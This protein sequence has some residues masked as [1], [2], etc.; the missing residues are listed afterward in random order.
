MSAF[1]KKYSEAGGRPEEFRRN[2]I[3]S[4]KETTTPRAK[5]LADK[6]RRDPYSQHYQ[7]QVKPN[8][9][10]NYDPDK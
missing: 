8:G 1:A 3:K 2:L 10:E 7:E 9:L 5:A 4:L 6:I